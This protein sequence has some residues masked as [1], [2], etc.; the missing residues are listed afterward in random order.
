MIASP[1]TWQNWKKSYSLLTMNDQRK[2]RRAMVSSTTMRFVEESLLRRINKTQEIQ[3][4]DNNEIEKSREL[5]SS[6]G[7]KTWGRQWVDCRVIQIPQCNNAR[8][9]AYLHRNCSNNSEESFLPQLSSH[10]E[11]LQ[12]LR[13]W[14][15][16]GFSQAAQRCWIWRRLQTW[17]LCKP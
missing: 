15:F 10:T 3:R 16:W 12:V 1:P 9:A 14:F 4:K 11:E 17:I 6:R 8:L 13:I 2:R 5:A 7:R